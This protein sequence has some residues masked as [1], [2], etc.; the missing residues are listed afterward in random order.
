MPLTFHHLIPRS[1]HRTLLKRHIFTR[2][3]MSSRGASIC[4][5]CHNAIHRMYDNKTLALELNTID[6]L[7]EQEDVQRFCQWKSRQRSK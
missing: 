6:K 4:R 3:E 5:S 2:S 7:L 1:T